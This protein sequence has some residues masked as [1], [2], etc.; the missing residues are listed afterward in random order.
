[1]SELDAKAIG[2]RIATIR[3][4]HDITQ[5]TLAARIHVT[6]SALSQWERGVTMPRKAMQFRLADALR[7]DRSMLFKELVEQERVA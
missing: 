2:L 3:K 1:M 4:M 7:T 5:V 6:Q